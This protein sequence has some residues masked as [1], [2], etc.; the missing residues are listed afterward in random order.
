MFILVSHKYVG[1]FSPLVL[2]IFEIKLNTYVYAVLQH[3][4]PQVK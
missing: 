2:I 1:C 4:D 3:G